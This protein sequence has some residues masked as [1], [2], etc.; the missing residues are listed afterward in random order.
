MP[1]DRARGAIKP[2]IAAATSRARQIWLDL[3][4]LGDI[5]QRREEYG[6]L[7]K[8]RPDMEEADK[9]RHGSTGVRHIW[10]RRGGFLTLWRGTPV[11]ARFGA[12]SRRRYDFAAF[13][14]IWL[15]LAICGQIW[16]ALKGLK[17]TRQDCAGRPMFG[18]RRLRPQRF[19]AIGRPSSRIGYVLQ[20]STT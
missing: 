10:R 1:S 5:R 18:G 19:G 15:I 2:P 16:H 7:Y 9:I 11:A 12:N 4:R 6:P 20:Y 3:A 17:Y 14:M 8:I 13:D